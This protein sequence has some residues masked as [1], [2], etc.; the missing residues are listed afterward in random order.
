MR[1]FLAFL[2]LPFLAAL[3]AFFAF[4]LFIVGAKEIGASYS[5]DAAGS[6][7]AGAFLVA[8]FVTLVAV[9]IV[10]FRLDKKPITFGDAL[11]AGVALGNAPF[12]VVIVLALIVQAF[13]ATPT[14]H[15]NMWYGAAG[16]VRTITLS[17]LMGAAL[18]SVFWVVGLRGREVAGR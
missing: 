5:S 18:G 4:P 2:I 7:A 9:P 15:A 17:T 3:L 6:F 13:T 10:L 8:I 14:S 12:L 11:V 1:L 16:A